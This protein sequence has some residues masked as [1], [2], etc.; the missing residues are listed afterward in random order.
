MVSSFPP[1]RAGAE[2]YASSR[3]CGADISIVS[4]LANHTPSGSDSDFGFDASAFDPLGFGLS[5]LGFFPRD[6]HPFGAF[7]AFPPPSSQQSSFLWPFQ[8]QLLQA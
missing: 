5:S 4:Q 6:F 8:P 7:P 2:W 1:L 3:N